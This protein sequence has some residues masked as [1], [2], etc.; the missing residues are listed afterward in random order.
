MT[1]NF[2]ASTATRFRRCRGHKSNIA[3]VDQTKT[4]LFSS[5]FHQ[6]CVCHHNWHLNDAASMAMA[7]W[8]QARERCDKLSSDFL[9][10]VPS[11]CCAVHRMLSYVWQV[12]AIS[13][14]YYYYYFTSSFMLS[15]ERKRRARNRKGKKLYDGEPYTME[16]KIGLLK[17]IEW[18]QRTTNMK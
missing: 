9:L 14:I 5:F 7:I 10:F 13:D 11:F 3:R 6:S 2:T 18:T 17:E 12:F 16:T 8:R 15:V 4:K 1:H